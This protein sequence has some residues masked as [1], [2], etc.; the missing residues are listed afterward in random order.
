MI[1]PQIIARLRS[2]PVFAAMPPYMHERLARIAKVQSYN[3][4]GVVFKQWEIARGFYLVL[5]GQGQLIQQAADGSRRVLAV[6]NP[7]QYFNEAA[8]TQEMVEQA[9]FILT[10]PGYILSINRADYAV[11]PTTPPKNPPAQAQPQQPAQAPRPLQPSAPAQTPQPPQSAQRRIATPDVGQRALPTPT[12]DP[13]AQRKYGWL[14]PGERIQLM[15]RRHWWQAVRM[16][17]LPTLF[18][19]ALLIP[20][21]MV[22]SSVLRVI[23][24][25]AAIFIP[26][27]VMLYLF[28][29]W[30]NDW[31]IITDKRVLRVEQ[32]LIKFATQTQEVGLLS[33]QSVKASLPPLDPMARMLRYG[34][35]EIRT[36]GAA[37][38][39]TMDMIP[40][41]Q[42]IKDYVF[43]QTALARRAAGLT[44]DVQNGADDDEMPEAFGETNTDP[45]YAVKDGGF[46]S[47]KFTNGRGE[48]VY[49]RHWS[50]W[51]RAVSLPTLL[52]F[53]GLFV[54]LFGQ[55][56]T[57]LQGAGI[58]ATIG[59][60]VAILLGAVWFWLADWDWRNDLYI[61][62]DTVITLLNR[63][64]LYL[65]Y[66]EDQV[67]LSKIHNIEAVTVGLFRS[68]LDYGDVKVLLLG[69][70]APKVFHDV[71]SPLAVREEISR[72]QRIAAEQSREEEDRRNFD[73]IMER[74]QSRGVQL[75]SQP[76]QPKALTQQDIPTQPAP[77]QPPF[78]PQRPNLPR[79]R[80]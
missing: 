5:S 66:N 9:S 51:V 68:L 44:L 23:L 75:P 78:P 25:G 76:A 11:M 55:G 29:D 46:L 39:I 69:D 61:I 47:M 34:N 21:V 70:E 6:V 48:T 74:M 52:M 27:G 38:N 40:N 26:G 77:V 24:L 10:Q 71:A 16:M 13:D 14:N 32:E 15:T 73:A 36:A 54:V 35:V 8:L 72:R 62:S 50:L 80:V 31:L 37:G 56:L 17:W 20:V 60:V 49:R 67:L 59:G 30:R 63:S 18:F 79:R 1:D 22:E 7:G 42:Q 19:F 3:A 65:Q 57:F 28:L 58:L 45:G 43:R 4:G 2:L 33:V 12:G 64:P 53:G 41:P